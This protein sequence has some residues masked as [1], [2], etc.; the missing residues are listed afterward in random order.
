MKNGPYELIV[1]PYS[2][3]GKRYRGLY[4]YEHTINWW[5]LTGHVPEKGY[6]I[7]HINGNHRDNDTTNL[8]L[9]TSQ[10][11]RVLHGAAR[12]KKAEVII[13]CD[14]CQKTRKDIRSHIEYKKRQGQKYFFCSGSCQ[15][16]LQHKLGGKLR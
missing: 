1:A 12:S 9:V 10:E 2:Y 7:H 13:I 16:T 8:Q 14:N 15:A 11:H 3:P 4:A 5:L 6:E